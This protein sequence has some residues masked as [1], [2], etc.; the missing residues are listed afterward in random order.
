MVNSLENP[1]RETAISAV[2]WAISI[3]NVIYIAIAFLGVFFF[4]SAIEE[5]ILN[6][7][8]L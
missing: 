2:N 3:T 8:S 1:S 5:S 7:I 6:N 4:G